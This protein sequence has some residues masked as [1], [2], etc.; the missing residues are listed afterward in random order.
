M[1]SRSSTGRVVLLTGAAGGIGSAITQALLDAG[2]SIAAVDKDG[3]ALERLAERHEGVGERLAAIAAD[4]ASPAECANAVTD[5]AAK[6]GRLEAVINNAGIGMSTI[7]PDAEARHPGLEEL[8]PEIWDRFF[9]VNVRAPMLVTRAALPY[10]RARRWGRIVNNT[11]SYRTMLRVFPYGAAKAALE[12]MS[13]V[14]AEELAGSGITVN[15]LIPGGPTDTPFIAD[16]AGWPR[17]K[18]LRPQIMGPPAVWLMSEESGDVSGRRITAARWDA[19]LP[20]AEAAANAGRPI[21]WP[22]LGTDAVWLQGGST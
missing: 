7:R 3:A 8:T 4:L 13:A 5:A 6:F 14:W 12:S 15:V 22:E 9:A 18:M 2:H 1:Q 16:E 19:A 11:T 21:G 17:D 20:G 10:M